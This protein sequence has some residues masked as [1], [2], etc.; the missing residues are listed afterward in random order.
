VDDGDDREVVGTGNYREWHIPK[1]SDGRRAGLWMA[2]K[3][4]AIGSKL[5]EP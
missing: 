1:P 5:R 2:R 3:W 4:S